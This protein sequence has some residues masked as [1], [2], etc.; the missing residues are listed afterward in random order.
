MSSKNIQFIDLPA[1]QAT[2]RTELDTAI[3]KVL[4]HGKYI[5]GP[6]VSELEQQLC[7]F[8]GAKHCITC[9]NG[10]DALVMA[11]MAL[12]IGPG[13]AVIVP[14]FTFVATAEAPALLG[15]TPIFVDVDPDYFLMDPTS[16]EDACQ[17]ARNHGLNPRCVIPVDLFGQP[18]NYTAI[19]QFARDHNLHVI[20]DAAQSFGAE[21]NG[22]K[23]GSLA[24][25]TTT[26][27]FP[28]KPLGCYGD[29]GAIFT[30]NDE[31]AQRLKSIRVHGQ[32]TDKYDNVLIGV[33]GRMD[34]L[35]AAILIEKLKIYPEEIRKRDIVA[36][37]YSNDLKD[38][39]SVPGLMSGATSVWAQ[40][41]IR[42]P[43]DLRD[44]IA[45]EL[46]GKGIPVAVYYQKP[47]HLQTAYAH[48]PASTKT[49]QTSETLAKEVLSLPMHPYLDE[50]IQEHIIKCVNSLV[51]VDA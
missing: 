44:T 1:Q 15:A 50:Q 36:S 51:T 16:L 25:L 39:V 23:V 28:A 26:S 29:G 8:S 17:V 18:A 43:A 46:K 38:M 4:D 35:Q 41:T 22:S 13:D 20:A 37:R 31:L 27:F 7:E 49:L 6:E 9:S 14:S 12:E 21:L 5:M 19:N 32:G 48:Y 11:L 24:T 42:V 2:I 10:T 30:D 34:T 40:Y 45:I 33:N 3:K 47:L